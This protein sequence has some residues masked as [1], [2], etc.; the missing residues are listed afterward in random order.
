MKISVDF[1]SAAERSRGPYIWL[2]LATIL[3]VVSLATYLRARGTADSLNADL[4][5]AK[6]E[7]SDAQQRKDDASRITSAETTDAKLRAEYRAA[8]P[9]VEVLDAI[10]SLPSIRATAIKFDV[11]GGTAALEIVGPDN[12]EFVSV[13]EQ[14]QAALPRWR[15][16]IVQQTH[17]EGQVAMSLKLE[18]NDRP[19]DRGTQR[20]N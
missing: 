12:A 18:D 5:A 1:S 9:W 17:T 13:V 11:D 6:Y 15:V 10:E 20:K 14:L 2:G 19:V 7:W 16:R 3:F 8:L 4:V